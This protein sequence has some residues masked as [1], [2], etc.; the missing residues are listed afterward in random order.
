[1]GIFTLFIFG[2]KKNPDNRGGRVGGGYFWR[3]A[4][5][6]T[7]L[8]VFLFGSET[9]SSWQVFVFFFVSETPGDSGDFGLV[10]FLETPGGSED[11]DNFCFWRSQATVGFCFVFC[12]RD[13]R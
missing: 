3:Q 7:M 10:L 4:F 6:A 11:P 13:P 12:F 8:I 2:L 5:Q 9:P 1:M